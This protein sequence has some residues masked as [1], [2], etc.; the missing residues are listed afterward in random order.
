MIVA[1]G[2]VWVAVRILAGLDPVEQPASTIIKIT[3]AFIDFHIR[4]TMSYIS[5]YNNNS[6][7]WDV[8]FELWHKL[9]HFSRGIMYPSISG[10]RRVDGA[11]LLDFAEIY[12][13]PIYKL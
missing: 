6:I 9:S 3:Y 2:R 12:G 13:K 5:L 8:D 1:K 10:E 11:E 7:F 4:R